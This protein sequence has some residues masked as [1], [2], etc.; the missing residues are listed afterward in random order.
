MLWVIFDF[1]T[2]AIVSSVV[3]INSS[4]N[5]VILAVLF[6]SVVAL[7]A[8][9]GLVSLKGPIASICMSK[10]VLVLTVD[11]CSMV[12][13]LVVAE[14]M[15]GNIVVWHIPSSMEVEV[16]IRV[17]S[18]NW[19][20]LRKL[21]QGVIGSIVVSVNAMGIVW[22]NSISVMLSS[23]V[24]WLVLSVLLSLLGTLYWLWMVLAKSMM[25]VLMALSVMLRVVDHLSVSLLMS[26]WLI[27]MRL[28]WVLVWSPLVMSI[29]IWLVT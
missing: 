18:G 9:M 26:D 29:S 6:T 27:N 19:M 15:W 12:W 7:V 22:S 5:I 8:K 21:I 14:L 4:V 11:G 24:V 10:S 28:V 2:I 3:S 13:V 20:V 25:I 23:I 16:S 1:I 17:M